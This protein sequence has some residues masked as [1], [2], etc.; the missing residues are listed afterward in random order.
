[1][2]DQLPE[3][4]VQLSAQRLRMSVSDPALIK[5]NRLTVMDQFSGLLAM[6]SVSWR[7]GRGRTCTAWISVS[8]TRTIVLWTD[9]N[10]MNNGSASV[11]RKKAIRIGIVSE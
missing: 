7:E 5:S 6:L 2:P 3:V 4:P 10:A 1:M 8:C 11:G 9:A